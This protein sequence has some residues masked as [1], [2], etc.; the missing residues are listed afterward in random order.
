M[1]AGFIKLNRKSFDTWVWRDANDGKFDKWSAYCDLLREADYEE[2]I[3]LHKGTGKLIRYERGVVYRSIEWLA[4]RWGWNRKTV[5]KFIDDLQRSGMVSATIT[6]KFT[7]IKMLWYDDADDDEMRTE[8]RTAESLD[9][10]GYSDNHWMAKRTVD[11]QQNGREMDSRADT[12]KEREEVKEVK[13]LINNMVNLTEIDRMNPV[14]AY[15]KGLKDD[16]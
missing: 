11:G 6:P 2:K 4:N 5:R 15:I 10:C 12:S 13:E 16:I 7:A 9:S 8:K 3:S 14:E 1:S